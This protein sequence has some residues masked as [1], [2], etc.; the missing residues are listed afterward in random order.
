MHEV[1]GRL[2]VF[3]GGS[4]RL[5]FGEVGG[6]YIEMGVLPPGPLGQFA[7]LSDETANPIASFEQS[8][9]QP[10]A[11]VAGGASDKDKTLVR[12][13]LLDRGRDRRR[14]VHRR[15]TEGCGKMI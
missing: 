2:T 14:H 11:N 3:H 15:V 10:P 9:Y 1:V 7:W 12:T 4:H 8:R 6:D 13:G 5:S